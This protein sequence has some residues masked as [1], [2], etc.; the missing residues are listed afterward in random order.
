MGALGLSG[1]ELS[2]VTTPHQVQSLEGV[3]VR[4]ISCGENHT[5][6]CLRGGTVLSCGANDYQQCGRKGVLTKLGE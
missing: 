6:V 3:E 1:S 4:S 2:R 5:L